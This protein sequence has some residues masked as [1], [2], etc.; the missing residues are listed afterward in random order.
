MFENRQQK[1]AHKKTCANIGCS[2]VVTTN[3][4]NITIIVNGGG[5]ALQQVLDFASTQNTG[6]IITHLQGNP[7]EIQAAHKLGDTTLHQAL[8]KISHFTGPLVTRNITRMDRSNSIAKVIVDGKACEEPINRVL[9]VTEKRNREIANNPLIKK[10]LTKDMDQLM[11]PMPAS[12]KEWRTQR[13]A[14]RAVMA[15]KGAMNSRLKEMFPADPPPAPI[16]MKILACMVV[17][18]MDAMPT[19]Y[20][21]MVEYNKDLEHILQ[22]ILLMA[23]NQYTYKGGEWWTRVADGVGWMIC[24]NATELIEG[25]VRSTQQHAVDKMMTLMNDVAPGPEFH[26]LQSMA[27][28]LGCFNVSPSVQEVI[29]ILQHTPV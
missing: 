14:N 25:H 8:T 3:S 28:C 12:D 20:L 27:D 11:L 2:S 10:F 5:E 29:D 24:E 13:F 6:H 7:A 1:S 17:E 19:E 4:H 23:C 21:R 18:A 16:P 22:G 26:R 9:D 15:S